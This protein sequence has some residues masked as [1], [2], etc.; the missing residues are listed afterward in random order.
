MVPVPASVVL[1]RLASVSLVGEGYL[2]ADLIGDLEGRLDV[3]GTCAGSCST[4]SDCGKLRDAD[5]LL[6]ER[7]TGSLCT[8]GKTGGS[9]RWGSDCLRGGQ[10]GQGKESNERG[11]KHIELL[12]D[13]NK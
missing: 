12:V 9:I 1:A 13:F 11:G 7:R 2:T 5:T 4:S 10:M 3:A 6:I 8:I